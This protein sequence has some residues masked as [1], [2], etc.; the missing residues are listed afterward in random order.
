[1]ATESIESFPP[2]FQDGLLAV[3]VYIA[4]EPISPAEDE[5]DTGNAIQG[6]GLLLCSSW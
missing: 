1:M 2:G 5:H 3:L 6:E 4:L